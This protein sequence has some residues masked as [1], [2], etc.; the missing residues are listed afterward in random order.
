MLAP[1]RITR[2][3]R[4]GCLVENGVLLIC[5]EFLVR[6]WEWQNVHGAEAVQCG[7]LASFN[8]G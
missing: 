7:L 5:V 2:L 3:L 4:T 6:R 1:V 8:T